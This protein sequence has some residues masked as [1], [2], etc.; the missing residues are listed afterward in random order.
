MTISVCPAESARASAEVV[1]ALL[2]KPASYGTWADARVVSVE[3][4]G[5]AG[6][7]QQIRMR[8]PTWAPVFQIRFVVERVDDAAR[9]LELRGEFPFGLRMR[10]RF[11][12]RPLDASTSRIQFG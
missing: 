7:G 3:P 8:A 6:A 11:A 10:N 9:V 1:W 5:R 2:T 12:V 4:P